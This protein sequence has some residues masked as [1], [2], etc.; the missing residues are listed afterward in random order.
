MGREIRFCQLCGGR[1]AEK[2]VEDT[3]RP[4]CESCGHVVFLDPKIAAAALILTEGKLVLVRRGIEP[5]VGRWAFPSGYVDRGEAVE[6]AALREVKEETGLDVELSGLVGLYSRRGS[7]V[8][9]AV[10][11]ADAVG[12]TLRPGGDAQ[13]V[14]LFPLDGLPPLPFPHDE[15]ILADWR[16][17]G[18]SVREGRRR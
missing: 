14:A 9:L 2:Q 13:E 18:A 3:V 4:C 6:E 15:R 10:Y 17:L 7:S 5:A 8:V 12:G 11:A 16:A 1:L